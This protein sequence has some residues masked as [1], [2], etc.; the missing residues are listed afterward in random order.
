VPLAGG[1]V[2]DVDVARTLSWD[3]VVSIVEAF[4]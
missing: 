2:V 1:K 4:Y 3:E